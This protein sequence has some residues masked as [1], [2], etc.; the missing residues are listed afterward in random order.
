M[1]PKTKIKIYIKTSILQGSYFFYHCEAAEDG[2]GNLLRLLRS[3]N[4]SL[5]MTVKRYFCVSLSLILYQIPKEPNREHKFVLPAKLN[6]VECP[7]GAIRRSEL[8]N[9]VNL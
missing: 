9:R 2:R 5:A 6:P 4:E 3:S 8:F 7:V 1:A